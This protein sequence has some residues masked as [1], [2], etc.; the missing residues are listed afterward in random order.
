[1]EELSM[2]KEAVLLGGTA[3]ADLRVGAT[4]LKPRATMRLIRVVRMRSS[5]GERLATLSSFV[6]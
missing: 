3:M 2:V 6:G 4:F 5:A 1:M